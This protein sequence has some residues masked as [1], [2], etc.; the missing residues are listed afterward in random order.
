MGRPKKPPE[1]PLPDEAAA[2]SDQG[3]A[4]AKPK[5]DICIV[6]PQPLL[7]RLDATKD[8]LKRSRASVICEALEAWLR[9]HES[10]SSG[11][12]PPEK[13]AA[14]QRR[15]RK[16]K[17]MKEQRDEAGQSDRAAWVSAYIR[18]RRQTH[19][20]RMAANTTDEPSSLSDPLVGPS[21]IDEAPDVLEVPDI[22]PPTEPISNPAGGTTHSVE[23][24]VEDPTTTTPQ[25]FVESQQ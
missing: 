22:D 11:V 25:P 4:E 1:A 6:I 9:L 7:V 13:H 15:R 17:K 8:A 5:K 18:N 23:E 20:K 12:A 16:N 24:R 14:Q 19:T 10:G 21:D 3:K 2:K